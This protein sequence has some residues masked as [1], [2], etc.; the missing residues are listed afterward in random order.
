M[1]LNSLE[2]QDLPALPH[3]P[4]YPKN[5]SPGADCYSVWCHSGGTVCFSIWLVLVFCFLKTQGLQSVFR[6]SMA[7][8]KESKA[9]PRHILW[10]PF[11]SRYQPASPLVWV[12]TKTGQSGCLSL[13]ADPAQTPCWSVAF[14]LH[15]RK[16]RALPGPRLLSPAPAVATCRPSHAI[17][18]WLCCFSIFVKISS[19]CLRVTS[20][21]EASC[22]PPAQYPSQT[23]RY[24]AWWWPGHSEAAGPQCPSV[25]RRAQGRWG[26]GPWQILRQT[27]VLHS[28]DN[29]VY[30]KLK[31]EC[32]KKKF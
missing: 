32:W 1:L 9:S 15:C 31:P 14:S 25:D 29:S 7:V 27:L 18:N 8:R 11:L 23:G 5:G 13:R 19:T 16:H 22:L 28:L 12:V 4:I 2:F 24:T 26:H 10:N 21:R 17:W 3:P 6:E 20:G 30:S